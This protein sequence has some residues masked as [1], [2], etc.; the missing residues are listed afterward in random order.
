MRLNSLHRLIAYSCALLAAACGSDGDTTI[1]DAAVSGDTSTTDFEAKASDFECLQD[2]TKVRSFRIANKLGNLDGAL[3]VANSGSG[4]TY[5]VGTIIQLVPTEAMVKRAEGFSPETK[6]WEF[7]SLSVSASGTD[8][9]TRG[10]RE[11]V[12]QFGLQCFSCHD[13][14]EPQ[15]DLVC[16][17]THGCDPLPLPTTFLE[18]LQ[19]TDPRCP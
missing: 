14:A 19:D 9:L 18:G 17:S 7:F 8:I 3:A 2:W 10:K 12:N 16:E 4:G 15:Y 13:K 1:A 5:P 11:V 6:D